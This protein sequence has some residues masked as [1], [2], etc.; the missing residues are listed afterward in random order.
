MNY[1]A[2]DSHKRYTLASVERAKGGILQEVRRSSCCQD[3]ED[4]T[5]TNRE[6]K[7][8]KSLR[9]AALSDLT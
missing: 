2:F 1:I 7:S 3:G 8:S 6:T 9:G 4:L 5:P